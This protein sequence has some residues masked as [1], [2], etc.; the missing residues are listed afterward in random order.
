MPVRPHVKI[1]FFTH[2]DHVLRCPPFLPVP[3]SVKFV[4]DLIQDVARCTWPY[5]LSRRLWRTDAISWMPSFCSNETEG[6][7]SQFLTPQIQ[8]IMAR[9]L[10][11]SRC[12]SVFFGPHVSLPCNMAEWTQASYTLPRILGERCLVVRTGKSF[13]NF[14]QVTQHLAV[15][16]LSQPPP[17][18]S[19]SPR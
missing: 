6:V 8:R 5:H 2:L 10:R 17:E 14:P 11:R 3:G 15:I 7:S 4:I 13:L 19:I 12:S 1:S 9:S 18:H 16:A